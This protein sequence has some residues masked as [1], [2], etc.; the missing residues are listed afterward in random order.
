MLGRIFLILVFMTRPV[1]E[2]FVLQTRL[3]LLLGT[4]GN[5]ER[6]KVLGRVAIMLRRIIF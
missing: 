1:E 3:V 5:G 2:V 6:S 4:G